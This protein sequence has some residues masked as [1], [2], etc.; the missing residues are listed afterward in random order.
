M[1]QIR[2]RFDKAFKRRIVEEVLSGTTTKAAASRQHN[3]AYPLICLWQKNYGLGRLDNEP[4]TTEGYQE[5]IAQLERKVGQLTIENDIFKKALQETLQD[6][7]NELSYGS[8]NNTC[9]TSNGGVEC[10]A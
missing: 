6:Q 4:I 8:I 5:K 2:R 10:S 1:K 3:I 9:P 7:E